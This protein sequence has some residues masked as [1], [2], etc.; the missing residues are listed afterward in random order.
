PLNRFVAGFIGSPSMNFVDVTVDGSGDTARLIGPGDWSLPTP[1]RLRGIAGDIAGKKLV[2]GF[3]PEHLDIGE[4]EPDSGSFQARA[5]V[6]EYL[7]NEELLHVNAANQDIVAIVGS[8]HRVKPGDI[9]TLN[10][11][12]SKL[13]LFDS[14]TGDALTSGRPAEAVA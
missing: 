13:H 1:Q 14:D 12:L 6:V 4:A 8:E 9:V 2:A 10:L 5:D 7:G 3:R 11:P